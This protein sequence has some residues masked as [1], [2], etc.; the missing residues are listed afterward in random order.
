MYYKKHRLLKSSAYDKKRIMAHFCKKSW[1]LSLAACPPHVF[2]SLRSEKGGKSFRSTPHPLSSL[3][4]PSKRGVGWN[5]TTCHLFPC[6]VWSLKYIG[7]RMP[8]TQDPLFLVD[9]LKMHRVHASRHRLNAEAKR[10]H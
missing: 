7:R 9:F 2:F 1:G 3:L 10:S 6:G 4:P 5:E 8:L